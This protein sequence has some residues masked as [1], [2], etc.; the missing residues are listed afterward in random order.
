MSAPKWTPGPW[1]AFDRTGD[2]GPLIDVF[3]Q[4]EEGIV[5]LITSIAE[6]E[7]SIEEDEG[8]IHLIAAAPDMYAAL[9]HAIK[10]AEDSRGDCGGYAI[11]VDECR[12]ALAKARGEQPK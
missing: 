5:D 7:C 8:N 10:D 11:D 12:A 1:I 3:K 9:E 2:D 4:R 6:S